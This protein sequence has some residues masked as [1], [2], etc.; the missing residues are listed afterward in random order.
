MSY[1]EGLSQIAGFAS[2]EA[3][4]IQH[5]AFEF[6]DVG[7]SYEYMP[8]AGE[9]LKGLDKEAARFLSDLGEVA[10]SDL[11]GFRVCVLLGLAY[12]KPSLPCCASSI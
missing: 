11:V 1:A 6:F 7:L 5:R 12:C 9:T 4:I 10:A 8:L 2:A 3:E